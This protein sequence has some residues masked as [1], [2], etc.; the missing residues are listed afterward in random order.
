MVQ[1]LALLMAAAVETLVK[2][3]KDLAIFFLYVYQLPRG[4]ISVF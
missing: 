1:L 4:I 2:S 3:G